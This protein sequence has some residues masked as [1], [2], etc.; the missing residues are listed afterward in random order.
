[1]TYAYDPANTFALEQLDHF[2]SC[3]SEGERFQ[4]IGVV[5]STSPQHVGRDDAIAMSGKVFDL[6]DPRVG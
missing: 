5:G 6:I 4:V 1:V 2:G 3:S